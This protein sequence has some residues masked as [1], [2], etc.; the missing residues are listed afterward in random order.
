MCNIKAWK[1]CGGI[2]GLRRA[3][4]IGSAHLGPHSIW[5]CLFFQRWY[6]TNYK[7]ASRES[8]WGLWRRLIKLIENAHQPQKST[9]LWV[10]DI[11]VSESIAISRKEQPRVFQHSGIISSA[12]QTQQIKNW[13]RHPRAF[14]YNKIKPSNCWRV[15]GVVPAPAK[16][17]IF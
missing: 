5:W 13:I 15:P 17:S 12:A 16:G 8:K 14:V 9:L 3:G 11:V 7:V 2:K 6:K 4:A 1:K 10:T